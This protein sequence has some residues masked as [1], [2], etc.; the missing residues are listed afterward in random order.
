MIILVKVAGI[1]FKTKI[2]N[3]AVIAPIIKLLLITF[4]NNLTAANSVNWCSSREV[5]NK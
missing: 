3:L 5:A 2:V 1:I 4:A